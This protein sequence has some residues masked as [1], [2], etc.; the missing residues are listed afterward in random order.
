MALSD[1]LRPWHG[2]M[3]LAFLFGAGVSIARRGS[4]GV[5]AL[6]DLF[7]PLLAGLFAVVVLQFTVGNVWGYAVEYVNA[8]GSW[9]DLPFLAPFVVGLLTAGAVLLVNPGQFTA[10]VFVAALWTGFWGF[11]A[12]A[13]VIAVVVWFLSGYRDGQS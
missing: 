13:G 3:L 7:V 4:A 5:F 2:L 9:T 6:P 11:V 8:G 12:A 1:R 10:P